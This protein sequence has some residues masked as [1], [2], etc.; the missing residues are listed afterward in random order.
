MAERLVSRPGHVLIWTGEVGP[1]KLPLWRGVNAFWA[2]PPPNLSLWGAL[3]AVQATTLAVAPSEAE[4]RALI[5]TTSAVYPSK[6]DRQQRQLSSMTS[7]KAEF[8]HRRAP[9]L[10]SVRAG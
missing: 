8:R 10:R 4:M 6:P 1:P 5:T 3:G 9:V 2:F 7:R